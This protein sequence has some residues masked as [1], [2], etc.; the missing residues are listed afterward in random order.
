MRDPYAGLAPLYDG[1]TRAHGIRAFYR[2]WRE[3]L[4]SAAKDRGVTGSVLVDLACGTGNSTIPWSRKAG[5]TVIGVDR[6][7]RCCVWRVGSRG[8]FA[9]SGRNSPS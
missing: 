8:R 4:L 1:M 5:W 7:P 3:A 6:R 2:Q 9:G